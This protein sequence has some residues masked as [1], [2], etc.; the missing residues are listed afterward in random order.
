MGDLGVVLFR[1][2]ADLVILD[3]LWL[4]WGFWRGMMSFEG[5]SEF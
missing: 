3:D 5:V 1:L 2:V 4:N